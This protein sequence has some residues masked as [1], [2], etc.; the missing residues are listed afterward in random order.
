M[1]LT[2]EVAVS[3]DRLLEQE[4]SIFGKNVLVIP[5]VE[6]T[7]V[8]R[9][10]PY[11]QVLVTFSSGTP[12]TKLLASGTAYKEIEY[13]HSFFSD[14][15]NIVDLNLEYMPA[16]IIVTYTRHESVLDLLSKSKL[17]CAITNM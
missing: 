17:K 16:C 15:G 6:N 10:I 13:L 12:P 7:P 5:N 3:V 8:K 2:F 9:L 14:F 4:L 1:C 11:H